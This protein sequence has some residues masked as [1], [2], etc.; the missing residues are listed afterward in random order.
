MARLAVPRTRLAIIVAA[1]ALLIAAVVL[2]VV[3]SG[4]GEP[5]PRTLAD[6]VPYDGRSPR[7]P[8][9]QGTRVI[10]AL[11]RPSLGEAGIAEPA[12]QRDYVRSLED[13][14]AALRSALGARGIRLSDVVTYTR[15]FNG[16]AATVRTDDLADLPSLGVTFQPVRRF[17]PATAEPAKVPGVRP[18]T[19]AAPLGGA[20]VAVLDT[21]VDATIRCWPTGSTRATTRSIATATRRRRAIRAAG[22]A[23]R[24]GPRWPGSSS[25]PASGCCRSAS[26]GSS[27]RRRAPGSR[28][29]PSPTSCSPGSS[30][31]SIP[32]ATAPPTT[33]SRSRSS[34]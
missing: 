8:S 22:G 13:E 20:S 3:L 32:T 33:T 14:S 30:A 4:P 11:P 17:Y 21:G 6:A 19:A 31:P 12:D 34:A 27:R 15:T 1:G 29:S 7:E 25:P 28:T 5:P 18:P 23:R 24:A 10:V 16:F 26:P 2:A 9:G